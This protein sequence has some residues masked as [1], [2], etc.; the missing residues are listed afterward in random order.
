MTVLTFSCWKGSYHPEI[1]RDHCIV[2]I[3]LDS[4]FSCQ[5]L[6]PPFFPLREYAAHQQEFDLSTPK[7]ASSHM[8]TCRQ[9]KCVILDLQ[10]L[11]S[12][13]YH[14]HAEHHSGMDSL[15]RLTSS[16]LAPHKGISFIAY[17]RKKKLMKPMEHLTFWPVRTTKHTSYIQF[18]SFICCFLFMMHTR[19]S[20]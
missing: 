2:L 15:M 20:K 16:D 12:R 6:Q 1:G 3:Q 13:W 5:W 14:I 11:S 7:Q 8:Q 9:V 19:Y 4:W 17:S 18:T 10:N